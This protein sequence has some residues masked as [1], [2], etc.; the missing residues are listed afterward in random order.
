MNDSPST[1]RFAVVG[2]PVK[3][4]RSPAIHEAFGR[5]TGIPLRYGLLESPLDGFARSVDGFFAQG[6]WGLNVTVPFKEEA[7]ALCG[8]GLSERARLAGAVN[9]LWM[10][11]GGLRGCNT[12]GVGL[13][14]DIARQGIDVAG[15]RVL[16]IGAGGAAKGVLFPL[17]EAGCARLRIVNRSAGRAQ[18]LKDHLDAQLAEHAGKVSAGALDRA[19]GE[20]DIVINATSSSLAGEAPAIASARYAPGALA[21]DMMY[22]PH[23]TPFLVQARAAGAGHVA[24]G[25]GMLVE[26]A[27]EAFFI[28]N[29]VRPDAGPVLAHLRSRMQGR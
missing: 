24:D 13:L 29:G 20:W 11:D 14:A 4:S 28:W 26:Q 17:L 15:K 16:L 25:L 12:D 8:T 18:G 27:A 1:R 9:T 5:Q 10:Q 3:H 19:E 2:N 6:G 7:H 23:P 22:G 21:Y